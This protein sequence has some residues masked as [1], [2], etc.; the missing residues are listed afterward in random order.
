MLTIKT[1]GGRE[2]GKKGLRDPEGVIHFL[3]FFH[4]AVVEN[5][6]IV[7]KLSAVSWDHTLLCDST[8]VHLFAVQ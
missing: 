5:S 1:E 6:V 4:T 7:T 8:C 3:F 2:R